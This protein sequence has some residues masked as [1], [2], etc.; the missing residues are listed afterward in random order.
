[1]TTK[2]IL[3]G[4]FN[5]FCG[6]LTLPGKNGAGGDLHVVKEQ[7]VS[8]SSI[9]FTLWEASFFSTLVSAGNK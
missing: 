3:N 4:H 8:R 5:H 7:K 9:Y 2:A 6:S 1:M